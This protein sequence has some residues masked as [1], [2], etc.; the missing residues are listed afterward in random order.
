MVDT[1][2]LYISAAK[3]LQV[4]RDFLSRNITE[5]PVP[6]GWQILFSPIKEKQINKDAIREA[7]VHLLI[8]GEDI[9]API[10][11]EWYLSRQAGRTPIAYLN[12]NTPR[13][14]AAQAF[15][16]DISYQVN[17]HFYDGL[18]DLRLQTL[19]QISQYILMQEVH[20]TLE[21]TDKEK[22]SDFIRELEDIEP[23]KIEGAQ[24]V[25]GEDSI[26]LSRERFTPRDGILIQGP[27]ESKE[28]NS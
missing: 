23:E 26:I 10:G 2:N 15:H 7:D 1:I 4:E 18:S 17:W 6:L 16:R 14:L 27:S 9:R 24:S 28:D 20:F 22:L 3:D 12:K 13:T 19:Q 8:L 11:Y 21:T 25:A 5:I